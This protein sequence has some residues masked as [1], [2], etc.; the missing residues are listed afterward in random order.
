MGFILLLACVFV[1]WEVYENL[2]F[3]GFFDNRKRK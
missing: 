1:G 3:A 2:V